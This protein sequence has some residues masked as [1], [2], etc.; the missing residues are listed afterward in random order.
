MKGCGI[1]EKVK[2]LNRDNSRNSTKKG[3]S[4]MS[5]DKKYRRE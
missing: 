4:I 5:S 3:G 1:T 2:D